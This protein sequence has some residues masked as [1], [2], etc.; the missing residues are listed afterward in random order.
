MI[1]EGPATEER[2]SRVDASDRE[3]NQANR[4]L[5]VVLLLSFG[6]L[7]IFLF[8]SGASA[9][10]TLRQLHEVEESARRKSLERERVL[11]TVIISTNIYSDHMEEFLLSSQQPEE[12]ATSEVSKQAEA[13]RSALQSYPVDR[14]PEEQ[15]LIQQLETYLVEQDSL[16]SSSKAWKPEERQSRAQQVI[17]EEIIPRRRE[18]VAIAQKVELLNDG[19]TLAA[20]QGGFVQFDYLQNRLMRMLI[21]AL[22]SGLLLAIGSAI[23]ILRLERQAALRYTELAHSRHELQELS[24]RLVDAQENERRSISRELHDEVGQALGLLLLDAGRLS[25]QLAS[26][27]EKGQETVQRIKTLAERTL[28]EVRNMALLLRPSMLDDLGL[29]A[30]VEW[31]A[32]EMSRRGETEVEVR[33]ENVT[34]DLADEMKLC[35]YRVV[36]EALN[37]AQR[38]AHAKNVV[39]ELTQADGAIRVKIADD[40]SGFDAKRTRGM[41]LL[42]MEERVKRLGGKIKVESQPGKGTTIEAE[43]H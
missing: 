16:I 41:G 13:A 12:D 35:V 30:A 11:T 19:Q 43:G 1:P 22:S 20:E 39:V 15:A 4:R 14:S 40:G 33:S 2:V 32:R 31:Y 25:K 37:N 36:Q 29:V 7:L 27:D 38:H 21:L 23:Y 9:L 6:G 17:H 10:Q 8:Y 3:G 24:T 42:G 18:F 28:Q 26:S 5:R 34:E